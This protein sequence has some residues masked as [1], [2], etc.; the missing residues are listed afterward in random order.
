MYVQA[1]L[2]K[3]ILK[4]SLVCPI[5]RGNNNDTIDKISLSSIKYLQKKVNMDLN[6][7]YERYAECFRITFPFAAL[8]TY[9]EWVNDVSANSA[10][11]VS[12]ADERSDICREQT[13][14][15]PGEEE[16]KENHGL[17]N[18]ALF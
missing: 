16:A 18:K 9:E 3:E 11:G 7:C 1:F 2:I 8:R 17:K 12:T 14:E 15:R 10:A 5:T 6:R 4:F 13:K